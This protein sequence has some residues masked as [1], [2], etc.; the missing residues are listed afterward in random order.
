MIT[1]KRNQKC[2]KSCIV[3]ELFYF[4]KLPDGL[5]IL[6]RS[7]SY[8]LFGVEAT[9]ESRRHDD[10][11]GDTW[12]VFPVLMVYIHLVKKERAHCNLGDG[13][14]CLIKYVNIANT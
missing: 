7:L 3:L 4:S 13:L 1:F 6:L 8:S 5:G 11:E 10:D 2:P 12:V 14:G 9:I